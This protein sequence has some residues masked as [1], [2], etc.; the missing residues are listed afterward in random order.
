MPNLQPVKWSD[1]WPT[2]GNNGVPYTSYT[3]PNV[4][5]SYPRM[6]LPTNDNFRSY[7][8]GMQWEWN[9]NPDDGGWSLFQRAGWLRL[10][11][12]TAEG[13]DVSPAPLKQAR[14]MLT[15]RIPVIHSKQSTPVK[16]TVKIDVSHLQ[17]GDRAGICVFQDPY[18]FIAVE[19]KDGQK[20]L[21]WHRDVVGTDGDAQPATKTLAVDID[22][23]IYLRAAVTYNSSLAA[24]YYSLDNNT[25][26]PLGEN[27]K[28]GYNLS[29][30]VGARFGL[31]CYNAGLQ[32]AAEAPA[33]GYADFDWFTTEDSYEETMF[34]PE[35]F[36]GFSEDMLTAERLS[37]S[38]M[39]SEVMVGNSGQ[40]DI[41]VTFRDGH[42]ENVASQARYET[43]GEGI[44]EIRNGRIIGIG[45][46]TA[47]VRV[48][49]TDPMGNQLTGK[50]TVRSTFF[51]FGKQYVKTDFFSNGTYAESTHTFKPGQW[52]QMGWQ[53]TNG[54]D[55]S[56]YKYLVIKLGATSSD[57]HL[58]IF[59]EN[60]IWSPCYSTTAFGSK[61]QIVVN[62]STA[63]YTSDG[64]KKGQ[65]L[66]TKNIHIVCFWG[67]GNQTIKVNEMYL[68]NNSDYTP[69]AIEAIDHSPLNIDH[70]VYDLQG[71][72]MANGQSLKRGLYIVNGRKVVVK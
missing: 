70:S 18:A 2:V 6:A 24:F 45:E 43:D 11:A 67:N 52:G 16:G 27:T 13:G 3:K 60:S 39:A 7:P 71:R 22:D 26:K 47:T 58:N 14:N 65:P 49:Y 42:T 69:S 61:K 17:E 35:D 55:M 36:E 29:V 57:S 9:H 63:K 59:T 48:F 51:P 10:Y 34:Y 32:E 31:F 19:V 38:A 20:Q 56:G 54:A 5:T 41:A 64:D 12:L 40:L 21:V 23:V 62:L 8:L 25:F 15:Q 33:T 1:G 66:D 50:F 44:I 68:T 37:L 46:G 4:G 30:F 72:R 28:L 53:Y